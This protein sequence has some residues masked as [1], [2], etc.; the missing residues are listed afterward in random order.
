MASS[1]AAGWILTFFLIEFL[2]HDPQLLERRLQ[3]KEPE[4]E[5][6]WFQRLFSGLTITGLALVGLDFRFG[7]T[8][9][10]L[11]P[12]PVTFVLVGQFLV[13]AGYWFVYWV[14][15]TNTFAGSTIQVE[16]AQTVIDRGPYAVVRHPMYLG[17]I[18]AMLALPVAL[19]SYV[20]VPLFALLVPTLVFRLVH[21]ERTLYRDL[22]GYA[23]YCFRTPYRLVPWVW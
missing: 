14:M 17:M 10:T 9:G 15:R 6:K 5:Q 4:P 16:A 2:A 3:R 13:V 19:G 11:G 20:T 1:I 8:R 12:V 23:Q 7:W 18:V 21:E 22:P